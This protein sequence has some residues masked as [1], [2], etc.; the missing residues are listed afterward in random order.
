MVGV[1]FLVQKKKCPVTCWTTSGESLV[2][3]RAD[4]SAEIHSDQSYVEIRMGVPAIACVV[5]SDEATLVL[6]DQNQNIFVHDLR[7]GQRIRSI[8]KYPQHNTLPGTVEFDWNVDIHFSEECN[9]IFFRS[10]FSRTEMALD[11]CKPRRVFLPIVKVDLT[12]GS[13][14]EIPD[15][16]TVC[17]SFTI[18]QKT[19]ALLAIRQQGSDFFL[20]T[21]GRISKLPS[22]DEWTGIAAIGESVITV[23]KK[24]IIIDESRF[25][26]FPQTGQAVVK[27]PTSS[28]RKLHPGLTV[29]KKHSEVR[30]VPFL[31][32]SLLGL[33]LGHSDNNTFPITK[34]FESRS[35]MVR[36]SFSYCQ[37]G[38]FIV[39]CGNKLLKLGEDGW[40]TLP[41]GVSP[42]DDFSVSPSGKVWIISNRSEIAIFDD[43]THLSGNERPVALSTIDEQI[44][45]SMKKESIEFFFENS[46]Q[47][48]LGFDCMTK[49]ACE[50]LSDL[51][52]LDPNNL[53]VVSEGFARVVNITESS[54]TVSF[55]SLESM[56]DIGVAPS[57]VPAT[58]L[59]DVTGGWISSRG[60]QADQ[61]DITIGGFMSAGKKL[62]QI[63]PGSVRMA[64]IVIFTASVDVAITGWSDDRDGYLSV[65]LSSGRVIEVSETGERGS[66]DSGVVDPSAIAVD[67]ENIT[68]IGNFEGDIFQFENHKLKSILALSE[69]P[70]ETIVVSQD[71]A[72]VSWRNGLVAV[73]KD[74]RC[75]K[76]FTLEGAVKIAKLSEE[77]FLVYAQ[78]LYVLS[79]R[80]D[81]KVRS[82][83]LGH[84]GSIGSLTVDREGGNIFSFFPESQ[85]F[86][87]FSLDVFGNQNSASY[88]KILPFEASAMVSAN[89]G[90]LVFLYILGALEKIHRHAL[91]ILLLDK[92]RIGLVGL[93]DAVSVSGVLPFNEVREEPVC[94][95]LWSSDMFPDGGLVAVGTKGQVRGRLILFDRESMHA[96]AKTSVPSSEL[97]CITQIS[98]AVLAIGCEDCVALLGLRPGPRT[99]PVVLCTLATL[100]TY[101]AV[102]SICMVDTQR[103]LIVTDNGSVQL[104]S[105]NAGENSLVCEGTLES[106]TKIVSGC[107]ILPGTSMFACSDAHGNLLVYEA[108]AAAPALAGLMTLVH[109]KSIGSMITASCVRHGKLVVTLEN[110]SI[111][112]IS[113]SDIRSTSLST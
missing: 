110:G 26:A 102:K 53:L 77:S 23:G 46:V 39:C 51:F 107:H 7:S 30:T 37:S 71:C 94:V 49:Q 38:H 79:V 35:I 88:N 66:W 83:E 89:E 74:G 24:G 6:L 65:L 25:L 62:V 75:V 69:A 17:L 10:D 19:G 63:T 80:D 72:V 82:V 103:F 104:L 5:T 22:F 33:S 101:A 32:D 73:L 44:L 55:V 18:S 81:I 96:I 20:N 92:S 67:A 56:P 45:A 90:S 31:E 59:S 21:D 57:L 2:A 112:D 70:V 43:A 29:V 34:E 14:S 85:R 40:E 3:V 105:Y 84:G 36:T 76:K 108:K 78:K 64:G 11:A 15:E 42:D 27:S 60:L 1:S 12:H 48:S 52:V 109:K 100:T 68:I 8:E 47:A 41:N 106:P 61:A 13:R 97:F 98:P 111:I 54:S 58:I 50:T 28:P 113:L 93:N 9:A 95:A 16:G 4:G 91:F 87:R 99:M 86:V